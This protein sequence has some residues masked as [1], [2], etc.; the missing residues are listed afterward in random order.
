M[1]LEMGGF[2][3][4]LIEEF[5][6]FEVFNILKENTIVYYLKSKISKINLKNKLENI[7]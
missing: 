1:A 5:K 7:I 4:F 2:G 3:E 6:N